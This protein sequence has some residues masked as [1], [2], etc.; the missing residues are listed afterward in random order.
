LPDDIE[1]VIRILVRAR[2]V[3]DHDGTVRARKEGTGR[4]P[5]GKTLDGWRV[6]Q[7]QH[8]PDFMRQQKT[9]VPGLF[10]LEEDKCILGAACAPI[11]RP[12]FGWRAGLLG[13]PGGG[14]P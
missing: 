11:L 9:I 2:P 7:A 5:R 13:R 6:Q 8:V 3:G 14:P 10:D 1:V 4:E 12:A